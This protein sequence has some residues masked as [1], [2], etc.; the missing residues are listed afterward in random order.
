MFAVNE[1]CEHLILLRGKVFMIKLY[2][3][4]DM[5]KFAYLKHLLETEEIPFVVRGENF[6]GGAAGEVPPLVYSAEIWVRNE[7]DFERAVGFVKRSE[8]RV[9]DNQNWICPACK[10]VLEGQFTLC[11]K[12]GQEKSEVRS[13][14]G[15]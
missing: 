10:E 2:D 9:H 13:L 15:E 11:W 1:V 12:C 3:T 4:L 6:N 7:A 5:A 8:W 14:G